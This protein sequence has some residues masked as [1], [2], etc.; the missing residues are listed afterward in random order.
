MKTRFLFPYRFRKIGWIITIPSFIFMMFNF[1]ADYKFP[2]LEF[3]MVKKDHIDFDRN[4][5]FSLQVHNFSADLG[6]ILVILG[7]LFIAFSREKKE[8]ERIATLR[9]ESL[10]WAV[11]FNSLFII[12]S[13]VFFYSELFLQIMTYNLCTTLIFFIAR[14]NLVMYL[15]KRKLNAELQ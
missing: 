6:G 8:D 14:F 2:F 10:L 12:F 15:E 9:L 4:F 11:Y 7:L 1:Y 3:Q 5:L 13:I